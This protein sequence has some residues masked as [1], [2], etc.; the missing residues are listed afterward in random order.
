V[1]AALVLAA[2]GV[3]FRDLAGMALEDYFYGYFFDRYPLFIFAIVY[4]VARIVLAAFEP[5]AR[6]SWARVVSVPAALV[7][8]LAACFH[9]T[10]GG[11]VV[12]AGFAT[13][14]V[15]FMS[16][17]P[18]PPSLA[19]GTAA[20][21]AF[22]ALVLYG[23]VALARLRMPLGWRPLLRFAL[24]FLA[25]WWA[26]AVLIS[27]SIFGIDALARWPGR[28]PG[29]ST[30]WVAAALVLAAFLPDTLLGATRR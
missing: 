28:P 12:R 16:P 26:A 14:A 21:A 8:F 5:G 13:G 15:M 7:L 9:P 25:L 24:S 6:A 29:S 11:L 22:Y 19:A 27:P 4:G 10:F 17:Q 3:T 23:A 2:T 30:G 1:A 20:A 18:L